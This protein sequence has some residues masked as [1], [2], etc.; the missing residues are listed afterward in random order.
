MHRGSGRV[1]LT[2]SEKVELGEK[3]HDASDI[4]FE[5]PHG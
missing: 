2:K 5:W 4:L 3:C 1:K